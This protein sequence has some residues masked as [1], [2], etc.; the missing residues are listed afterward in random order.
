MYKVSLVALC[1]GALA[2][3]RPQ[4]PAGQPIA[5]LS[6]TN[7]IFPDT[8]SYKW[9]SDALTACFAGNVKLMLLKLDNDAFIL[10]ALHNNQNWRTTIGLTMS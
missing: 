5:I 10:K 6:Q 3:A 4:A 7:E 8:G 1:M 9:S 2:N